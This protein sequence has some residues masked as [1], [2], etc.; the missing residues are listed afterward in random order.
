MGGF[1]I[2][3]TDHRLGS[4]LSFSGHGAIGLRIWVPLMEPV[5][6]RIRGREGGDVIQDGAI[7]HH[8]I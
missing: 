4:G 3:E 6:E 1:R 5:K 7:A 8:R 2:S